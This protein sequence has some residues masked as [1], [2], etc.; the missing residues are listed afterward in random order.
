MKSF[1]YLKTF[2]TNLIRLV[3]LLLAPVLLSGCVQEVL[4]SVRSPSYVPKPVGGILDLTGSNSLRGS[5]PLSDSVIRLDGEWEFYWSRLLQFGEFENEAP[6]LIAE[7]PSVWNKYKLGTSSIHKSR[8]LI[9]GVQL[10][11]DRGANAQ[12][13]DGIS[14]DVHLSG[15]GYATYRLQV[16]TDLSP[17][18]LM[19][20]KLTNFS[21]AYRYFV[22]GQEVSSGGRVGTSVRE[23]IPEYSAETVIFAIPSEKFEL[24]VHV[25]NFN[26]A[27]GGYWSTS[28]LGLSQQILGMEQATRFQ[29]SFL[30][31]TLV[32]VVLLFLFSYLLNPQNS[33]SLYFGLACFFTAISVDAAGDMEILRWLGILSFRQM[34][35]IW[36]L[37][38][39]WLTLAL[40]LY[41]NELFPSPYS[42]VSTRIL[43]GYA[44]L[45]HLTY[46]IIPPEIF[47]GWS[48]LILLELVFLLNLLV[49]IWQGVR[50]KQ[51]DSIISFISM[52]M[53]L[54]LYIYGELIATNMLLYQRWLLLLGIFLYILVQI[55]IQA[56]RY[57]RTYERIV[58]TELAFFQAQI[59]PHF[60]FN[61]INTIISISR[62]DADKARELL[63]SLSSY[64]R[65]SFDLKE[66][67]QT[68]PLK[69]EIELAKAYVEISKA[70]FEDM[71][72]VVFRVEA[73]MEARVPILMLQPIVE[74]AIIH[75]VLPKEGGGQVE[76]VV[77]ERD[78]GILFRVKDDGVGMADEESGGLTVGFGLEEDGPQKRNIPKGNHLWR[79][80]D[81]ILKRI[82]KRISDGIPNR[83]FKRIF[84]WIGSPS[85]REVSGKK[86]HSIGRQGVGIININSRL[87]RL[88]GNDLKI[89]SSPG[90]GTEVM[91]VIPIR[92]ERGKILGGIMG[93]INRKSNHDRE[94]RIKD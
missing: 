73:P 42:R 82:H 87:K 32:A 58:N 89:T 1:S 48:A 11:A 75:G 66:L 65:K 29:Y 59:K 4:G 49:I 61:T 85:E 84:I 19:G 15:T 26:H 81:R 38:V 14:P 67:D 45:A 22:D 13:R 76:I 5:T 3:L 70:R 17:G 30:L 36:Y 6:D 20:L 94:K 27:R 16:K 62:Y 80:P 18:T 53:L 74:N 63:A 52:L 35:I 24:I 33:Y 91:W 72:E 10:P 8:N 51:P 79:I 64:L 90:K 46:F 2:H 37:S 54:S 12:T 34:V 43:M 44:L 92:S 78:G 56:K 55:F 88:Y 93:W 83:F 9:Q 31:G 71:L 47:S 40:T 21:S 41:Y 23:E 28:F 57:K 69:D 50:E 25:S 77:E 39:I 86:P 60:L 68:V 7:V